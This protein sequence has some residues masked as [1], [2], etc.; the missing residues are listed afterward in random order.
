ML[1]I[2]TLLG[3][4]ISWSQNNIN[5]SSTGGLLVP[6]TTIEVPISVVRIINKKFIER[7]YYMNIADAQDSVIDLQKSYIEE[8]RYIIGDLQSRIS[9]ANRINCN[10]RDECEKRKKKEII[11]GC[12]A[13][14]FATTTIVATFICIFKK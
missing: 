4:S 5:N 12:A 3:H 10:I 8:Q 1:L 14:T 9:E 2:M 11:F 7:K 6:D 13:L